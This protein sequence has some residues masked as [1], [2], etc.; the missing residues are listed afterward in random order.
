[1]LDS[2]GDFSTAAIAF[3]SFS[4]GCSSLTASGG[5]GGCSGLA[6]LAGSAGISGAGAASLGGGD[7]LTCSIA[8]ALWSKAVSKSGALACA[9]APASFLPTTTPSTK[10]VPTTT[11]AA[12]KKVTICRLSSDSSYLSLM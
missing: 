3:L 5:G 10:T 1:M 9:G 11:I 7:V 6:T 8:A 2:R 12:T 4:R